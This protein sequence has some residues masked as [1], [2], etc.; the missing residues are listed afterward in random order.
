MLPADL[1]GAL[2]AYALNRDPLPNG[3][4]APL[5]SPPLATLLSLGQQVQ[6]SVVAQVATGLY[7]VKIAGQ[8]VQLPLPPSLATGQSVT[9]TVTGLTP[10][11]TFSMAAASSPSLPYA[12]SSSTMAQ[13]G[14]AAQWLSDLAQTP[15]QA[16]PGSVVPLMSRTS[17]PAPEQLAQILQ[18]ALTT[19]G[20]FY[21]AHQAQWVNGQQPTELLRSQPQNHPP[22]ASVAVPAVPTGDVASWPPMAVS[23]GG[24]RVVPPGSQSLNS[25]SSAGTLTSPLALP[26]HLQ[27]LVQQQLHA[28]ESGQLV[29]QGQLGPQQPMHWR[30]WQE[31]PQ[32]AP[33]AQSQASSLWHTDIEVTLPALGQVAVHLTWSHQGVALKLS[34]EQTSTHHTLIQQRAALVD[35]MGQA[36]LVVTRADMMAWGSGGDHGFP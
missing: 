7:N 23:M 8:L 18:Q 25:L 14:G 15:Q 29:W 1:L 12:G 13:L 28:L 26:P 31:S 6:A 4:V 16:L 32:G 35:A 11:L 2:Q 17:A 10:Q 22:P 27:G 9:L 33:S 5:S 24:Q 21:E 19:S 36:G 30:I 34:A 20:L 3:S